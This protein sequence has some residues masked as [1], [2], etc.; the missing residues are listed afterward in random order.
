MATFTVWNRETRSPGES[1]TVKLVDVESVADSVQRD[2]NSRKKFCTLII[3]KTGKKIITV[4]PAGEVQDRLNDDIAV[5][6]DLGGMGGMFDE[7]ETEDE[8]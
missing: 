7:P 8:D 2:N 1:I 4:E 6:P 5:A 3:L